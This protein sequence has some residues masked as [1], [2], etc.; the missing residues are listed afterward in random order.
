MI[1]YTAICFE[2]GVDYQATVTKPLKYRDIRY[3]KGFEDFLRKKHCLIRYVN[4]YDNRT[5]KFIERVY[6]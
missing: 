5:K 2:I 3:R 4:Y 1:F 6:L